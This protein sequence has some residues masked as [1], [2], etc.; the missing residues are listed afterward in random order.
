MMYKIQLNA[1]GTHTL[2]VSNEHL[3]TIRRY[4]LFKDLIDSNGYV[5]EMVLNKLKLNIRA[6]IDADPQENKELLTL[7]ND[8]VYHKKMKAFGLHQLILLYINWANQLIEE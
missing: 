5:E 8:V 6:L 7:C 2:N 1:S 4:A 3:E